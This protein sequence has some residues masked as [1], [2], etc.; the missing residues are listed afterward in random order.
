MSVF[1]TY[2]VIIF[3]RDSFLAICVSCVLPINNLLG[4][5]FT[6]QPT[7]LFPCCCCCCCSDPFSNVQVCVCRNQ[8]KILPLRAHTHTHAHAR[9]ATSGRRLILKSPCRRRRCFML[10]LGAAALPRRLTHSLVRCN[11]S[12]SLDT[13]RYSQR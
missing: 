2:I 12:D 8:H 6:R 11:C 4:S 1:Y 10:P 9:S 3:L 5:V 7:S 13:T